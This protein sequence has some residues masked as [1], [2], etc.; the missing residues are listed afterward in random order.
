MEIYKKFC[1]DCIQ[2]K[3]GYKCDFHILDSLGKR[4]NENK[5]NNNEKTVDVSILS[6]TQAAVDQAKSE[7]RQEMH[8]NESPM[9]K[10][11]Q[12]GGNSYRRQIKTVKL[13]KQTQKIKPTG[14]KKKN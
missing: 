10:Q 5:N 3:I 1:K 4:T 2:G 13:R 12:S 14:T 8:I 6:P 9:M 11:V 7:L